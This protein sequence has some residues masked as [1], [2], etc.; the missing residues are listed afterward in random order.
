MY[1]TPSN[2]RSIWQIVNSFV[3]Y[4]VLWYL[5]LHTIQQS[6]WH[7]LPFAILAGLFTIRLFIVLH[8]CSHRSFFKSHAAN[9][10]LGFIAGVL[11][12][13]PFQQWRWEHAHHHG[14]AGNLD[15]RGTGDIWTLTVQ[16]YIASSRWKRF[17]YR[18]AR[19][20]V[21][22]F[23][24]APLFLFV[25]WHRF[26]LPKAGRRETES[27]YLTNLAIVGMATGLSL[28][29]GF[30]AYLLIQLTIIAVAS[31]LGVWLFYVQ[32]QFEGVYWQRHEDWDYATAALRGSSFYKLPQL[33]NWFSGSIGFHHIHHLSSRIPNYN[34]RK[35]HHAEPMMQTVKPVTLVAS[36]KSFTFRLWDEQRC[37][38]VG[39]EILKTLRCQP[40]TA[41]DV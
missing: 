24:V 30:K 20:P 40:R 1:E 3:P 15:R 33:L 8:D 26:P 25:V 37:K 16:E 4:A 21:I 2:W 34:L 29:F 38:L 6:Y 39:F 28:L 11:T 36:F 10:V 5:M 41:P 19:N 31:S 27:V 7:T 23:L 12:L 13:T 9:E 14:T 35:C 18:L 32:H 17:A 22:L